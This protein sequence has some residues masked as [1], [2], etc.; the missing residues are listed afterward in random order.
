MVAHDIAV[1][2]ILVGILVP[3]CSSLNVQALPVSGTG[4]GIREDGP[5][6]AQLDAMIEYSI[7]VYNLGDYWIRNITLT[8]TFPNGTSVS[9]KVPD[10][11]PMGEAG[12]SYNKSGIGYTIMMEDLL[13]P[14]SSGNDSALGLPIVINTAEVIGYADVQDLGLLVQ[15]ETNYLTSVI[16][17]FLGGYSVSIKTTD[18]SMPATGQID[19]LLLTITATIS[20]LAVGVEATRLRIRTLG[21][22]RDCK[23]L[24]NRPLFFL[25]CSQMI[26]SSS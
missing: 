6:V 8:D 22:R 19:F 21:K 9:W 17:P 12:S 25:Y 13:P 26:N 18:P 4:V 11:A 10:L 16:I 3:F 20:I 14:P 15:A 7:T 23:K 1:L 2:L 24:K 5:E